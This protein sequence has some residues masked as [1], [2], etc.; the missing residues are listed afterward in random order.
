MSTTIR[1]LTTAVLDALAATPGLAS[2]RLAGGAAPPDAANLPAGS[3]VLLDAAATDDI[4]RLVRVRFELTVWRR[5]ADAQA[6]ALALTELAEAAADTLLAEPTLAGRAVPNPDGSAIQIVRLASGRAAPPLGCATLQIVCH[7]LADDGLAPA[8]PDQQVRIDDEPLLAS[9]PHAIT[10]G[11]FKRRRIDR[12]FAGIDGV[13][14]IDLGAG[15]RAIAIAGRLVASDR[16]GLLDQMAALSALNASA[17]LHTLQVG[18]GRTFANV[19]LEH[20]RW[21][22]LLLAGPDARSA[23]GYEMQLVQL[24]E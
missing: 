20:I 13:V 3:L 19:R 15:G 5:D 6:N 17:G 10:V 2:V 24:A 12:T 18:D 1:D 21:G 9:G 11:Q 16:D 8:P 7:S 4:D 23:V 14:S 22:R